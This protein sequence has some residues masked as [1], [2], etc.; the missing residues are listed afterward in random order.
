MFP[1]A[2]D[3]VVEGVHSCAF[4]VLRG[5]NIDVFAVRVE[6]IYILFLRSTAVGC[7]AIAFSVAVLRRASAAVGHGKGVVSRSF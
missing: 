1:G 2:D 4:G 6:G 3:I 5:M 7:G